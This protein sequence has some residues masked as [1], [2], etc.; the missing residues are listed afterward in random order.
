MSHQPMEETDL[1]RVFNDLAKEAWD[2]TLAWPALAQD[3]LGKQ[4]VRAIDSVGANLVGGDGRYSDAEAL[5]FFE[6]ARGSAR[7]ADQMLKRIESGQKMLNSLINYRRRTKN[8]GIVRETV[9]IYRLGTLSHLAPSAPRLAPG[10]S[11]QISH[12]GDL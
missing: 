10:A 3:I 12:G 9:S 6:F 4:F 7:E 11:F 1:F 2:L 5:H 8:K